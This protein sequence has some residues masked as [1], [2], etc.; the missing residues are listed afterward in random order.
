MTAIWHVVSAA[1]GYTLSLSRGPVIYAL[2]ALT[3]LAFAVTSLDSA[4]KTLVNDSTRIISESRRGKKIS[5][6]RILNIVTYSTMGILG[7]LNV[8]LL[9]TGFPRVF[10]IVFCLVFV[11]FFVRAIIYS[12]K[13][14]IGKMD[15]SKSGTISS[16]EYKAISEQS[17]EK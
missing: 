3:M 14:A 17:V 8:I 4:T 16:E 2:T 5:Q 6:E 11:P 13:F 7:V 1:T 15:Y 10:T 9:I 12:F